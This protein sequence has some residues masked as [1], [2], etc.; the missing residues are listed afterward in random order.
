MKP[1][2]QRVRLAALLGFLAVALGAAGA[3]GGI[4]EILK[5]RGTVDI[6]KTASHYHFVH[7]I[8]LLVLAIAGGKD[9]AGRYAWWALLAGVL[10]FSGTLYVLAATGIKWLGAITPVG[11]LLLLVGWLLIALR[12]WRAD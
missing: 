9:A 2:P 10:I 4:E 5:Q 12:K 8:A 1:E 11:G 7:A 3:H 6:W